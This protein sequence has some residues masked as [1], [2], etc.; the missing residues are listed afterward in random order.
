MECRHLFVECKDNFKAFEDLMP[1][2]YTLFHEGKEKL[3]TK[4]EAE[5][6]K[7]AYTQ[8]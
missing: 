6:I 3:N 1:D 2:M 7:N 4:D 5:Y 8:F